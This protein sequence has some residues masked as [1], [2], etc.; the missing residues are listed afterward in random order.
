MTIKTISATIFLGFISG[1]LGTALLVGAILAC[2]LYKPEAVWKVLPAPVSST[3][4]SAVS[5]APVADRDNQV[6]TVVDKVKPAVVSI[7]A[8]QD[9]PV[10]EQ[11]Y[12]QQDFFGFSMPQYRQNGTQKQEVS[13]GSGFLVSADGYIVT[14]KHV[15]SDDTADYT[16]YA[17]DGT[18]YPAIVVARDPANDIAIIKIDGNDFTF[19]EFG[20]SDQLNVGQTTIAIGN[21]LGEFSNSVSVGIVSGLA[22]SIQAGDG[23]GKAEQLQGL[24][25]T[26]AAINLGN[27]GGPLLDLSGKV[28]GVN[29]AMAQAENIGFALPGNLVKSTFE[30]VKTTGKISRSYLGVRY[31]NITPDLKKKNNLPVD[32]GALV[33]RG[34]DPTDLA[35]VPSSPADK[36]GIQENDIILKINDQT[37]D[38]K[39]DL[40][41]LISQYKVGD[42]V[43]LQVLHDGEEKDIFVTLE[44]R[45]Q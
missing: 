36:A 31:M 2:F 6:V 42:K 30:T 35:V 7:V 10:Y 13:S 40:T 20:D 14:N 23:S 27:S 11:Y 15:V 34:Q 3:T 1:L 32:A 39:H 37:L 43:T 33:L 38:E 9:V 17:N 41:T 5:V 12:D 28:I 22:R 26:D 4:S 45:T 21:A 8:T 29:V 24:V 44:E 16:V 25:Q 19:L 18:K